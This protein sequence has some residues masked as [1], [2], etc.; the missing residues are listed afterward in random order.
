[1]SYRVLAAAARWTGDVRTAKIRVYADDDYR[2]QNLRWQQTFGE[3]LDYANAVLEPV[4]GL[5][6]IAE[7]R[8]W[9]FR[10][11]AGARSPTTRMPGHHVIVRGC[12]DL[13]E[14]NA[15]PRAVPDLSGD[16]ALHPQP[17][18]AP[19]MLPA[20]ASCTPRRRSRSVTTARSSTR[21][22]SMS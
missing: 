4:L 2:A 1:M 11:I 3:E 20:P 15:F 21:R 10:A 17:C 12:A 14:R 19:P 9:D 8:E 6:L 18:V 7:Y 5:H 22:P 16:E 13:E